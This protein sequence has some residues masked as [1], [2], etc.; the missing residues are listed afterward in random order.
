LDYFGARYYRA[1]LG[2]FTTVDPELNVKDA[3]VDPQRWNR[4]AYARSNPLRFLDPDGR[5]DVYVAIWNRRLLGEGSVGHVAVTE[6]NGST[7]LSPFPDP[8]GTH[9]AN[10]ARDYPQT[11]DYEGRDPDRV[12]R[13][14]VPDDAGFDKAAGVHKARTNWDWTPSDDEKDSETNCVVAA[15]NSLQKGGVPVKSSMWPGNL[16]ADLNDMSKK[17]PEKG[18]KWKVVEVKVADIPKKGGGQ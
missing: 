16:G 3:L 17:K 4:Y 11:V 8:R 9:G 13:V 15:A 6:L 2:H 5:R 7:I 12:F 1:N 18:Q 10:K 14:T